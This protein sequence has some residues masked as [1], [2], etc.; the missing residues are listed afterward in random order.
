MEN[1]R[2]L[3]RIRLVVMAVG[4]V[5]SVGVIT[6]LRVGGHIAP[7]VKDSYFLSRLVTDNIGV[8]LLLS[9]FS[10]SGVLGLLLKRPVDIA[11]GMMAPLPLAF[12]VEVLLDAT[13]HNLF[14]FEALLYWLPAFGLAFLGGLLGMRLRRIRE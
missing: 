11:L 8:L 9:Y 4:L 12:L 1:E 7:P 13:S 14:P 10:T 2:G 5:S 6:L 3:W